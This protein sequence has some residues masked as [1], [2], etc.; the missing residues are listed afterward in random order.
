MTA[1]Q[2]PRIVKTHNA[3]Q[4]YVDGR[5]FLVRGAELQNSSFSSP[6]HMSGIWQKLVDMNVNTVLGSVSWEMI[7]R[8][9]GVFDF[10][11]VDQIIRDARAHGLRLILLWFGTWKNGEPQRRSQAIATV[12]A[13]ATF[14]GISTYAPSWVKMSPSRFP[15]VV[16]RGKDG[17]PKVTEILSAV[18]GETVQA[19][20]KAFCMLMKHLQ[21][22]DGKESTVIMVQVENEVGV[23]GDSRDRSVEA[24]TMFNSPVPEDL[25]DRLNTNRQLLNEVL[26]RRLEVVAPADAQ[27]K[28]GKSWPVTFGASVYTDELFMAY[29]YAKFVQEVAQCGKR[30]YALPMFANFWQN[31]GEDQMAMQYP[32]LAGGGDLPG[33]Y[34]SGGAVSNVLDVW[35]EFAPA[36]DFIAPDT[37]LNDYHRICSTYRH[38]EQALFIPEQRRD[39]YGARRI[40][41][42]IGAYQ[43]IGACPFALD[44]LEPADCPYTAHYGLLRQVS[45][46]VLQAQQR[47]GG[48]VGFFFDEPDNRDA[49]TFPAPFINMGGYEVRVERSFTTG[50]SGPG[51]G[52]IIDMGSRAPNTATF[53]LIGAGFQVKFASLEAGPYYTG[54]L[55]FEE[56]SWD[57]K[58]SQFVTVRRLN[59]DETRSGQQAIMPNAAPDD[60][61]FPIHITIPAVTRIAECTVYRLGGK[62]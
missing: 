55:D 33:D 62:S 16:L 6:R 12:K 19:D 36:L 42:A 39:E 21:A 46:V 54:I 5:P 32:T 8:Q 56:K 58:A 3:A 9:E 4:L 47:P 61:G 17:Q 52:M 14:P 40:W 41:A 49:S 51:Y 26:R 50:P 27:L 57:E 35:M 34:P 24:E 13:H 10:A 37:Y 20:R 53:L 44:T 43:A 2:I 18:H 59:G 28:K 30:E 11:V 15:R 7:E 38:R 60:G 23:L 29:H 1:H 45:D 25:I 22:F 48:I 31:Y